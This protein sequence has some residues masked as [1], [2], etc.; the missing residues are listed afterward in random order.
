MSASRRDASVSA[1]SSPVR[2]DEPSIRLTAAR[3]DALHRLHSG[4][5][6]IVHGCDAQLRDL[7]SAGL[8]K[9]RRRS[10]QAP[11]YEWCLTVRGAQALRDVGGESTKEN[12]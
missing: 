9:R 2:V 8:V 11:Q 7:A 6:C 12:P 4:A 5:W 1:A 10:R 3:I